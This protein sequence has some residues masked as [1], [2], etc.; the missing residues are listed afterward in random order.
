MQID[1]SKQRHDSEAAVPAAATGVSPAN[2]NV[3]SARRE[4]GG[5]PAPLAGGKLRALAAVFC[6]NEH[7]KIERTLGRFPAE[8]DYD[9][10]VIN[11][12]STDDSVERVKKFS[13]VGII[14]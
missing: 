4:T 10:L 13:G 2:G 7:V 12:G 1:W 6:Y 14:S 11:D 5:T 9:L 3:D 8:R